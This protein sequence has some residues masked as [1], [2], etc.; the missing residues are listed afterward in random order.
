MNSYPPNFNPQ[1]PRQGQPPQQGQTPQQGQYQPGQYQP[2]QYRPGQYQQSQYRPGP[3]QPP[4]PV[5]TSGKAIAGMVLGICSIALTSGIVVPLVCAILGLVFSVQ[6]KNEC[7]QNPYLRGAGMAKA[8]LVCSIIGLVLTVIVGAFY[9]LS[10]LTAF[11]LF[12]SS[13]YY[14]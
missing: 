8:G 5:K 3:Y 4:M 12:D 11:S 13:I 14:F 7:R 1:N 2:G 10:L 9:L 6:G